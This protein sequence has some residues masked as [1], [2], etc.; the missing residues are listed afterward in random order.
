MASPERA[1]VGQGPREIEADGWWCCR[2]GSG[3]MASTFDADEIEGRV[4][5]E[6]VRSTPRM[7]GL[8]G[9][10]FGAD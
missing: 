10:T 6:C 2:L 3:C 8:M 4:V 5:T 1:D 9:S 7:P